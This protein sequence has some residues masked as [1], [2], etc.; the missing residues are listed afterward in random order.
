[1]DRAIVQPGALPQDTDILLTNKFA[2]LGQAYQNMALLGTSTVVAGLAATPTSPT[3][4]LHVTIGVGTIYQMTPTDAS[5]YGSLGVDNTSVMKQGVNS[6][7]QVLSIAPPA[8]SGFSQV[9]LVQAILNDADGGN[10]VLSYYNSA[11]PSQP[12]SGPGNAGTSNFT[13]RTSVCQIALKA[14]VAASTGTQ[15]APTPDAGYVGLYTITVA[16]GQTQI[17]STNIVQLA[18]APFFPSLPSVPSGVQNGTWVWGGS[19][20]GTA[21]NYAVTCT[22]I[23]IAYKAGMGI[24]FK[25]TNANSGASTINVNGL[26][27]VAIKRAGG[28]ALASGDIV[29]G[30]VVS[31]V[32]D[33]VNFQ[34]DNYLG[35]SGATTNITNN[36]IGLP[37]VNDTGSQNALIGTYSPAVTAYS[38]GLAITIKLANSITSSSTINCN[39]LGVKSI[40]L[41]DGTPT[42]A[43]MF[44]AGQILLLIY[45]GTAFQI[46]GTSSAVAK[47]LTSNYTMYVNKALGDDGNDG[48]ANVS[49]KALATIGRAMALAWAYGPS[50][51]TITIQVSAGT[52]NEPVSTPLQAG[53][54]VVI[55]GSGTSATTVN[56]GA[57]NTFVA[58]GPN[59]LTVQ[60]LNATNTGAQSN[61]VFLATQGASLTTNNTMSGNQAGNVF[62]G[63]SGGTVFPGNHTFNGNQYNCFSAVYGGTCTISTFTFTFAGPVSVT[64]AVAAAFGGGVLNV[65]NVNPPSFVNP[66]YVNGKK[67]D[68]QI[69]GVISLNG[70]GANF[71][72]G[73]VAGGTGNGGQFYP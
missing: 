6:S 38:A 64:N 34:M 4:D 45:D 31:L 46:Y 48:S 56:G 66:S 26:G 29:S 39:G 58:Q 23:P 5:A 2:L 35:I 24:R 41:G 8:T 44:V 40:T 67:F 17:T 36:S 18:T 57:N 72:P 33:G 7:P 13:I 70:L 20:T 25:A 32:Y 62:T 14:G 27:A 10:I 50:Q 43:N 16:N 53:P 42:L 55:N 52:Y 47:K 28:N 19:D 30:Q 3:A 60:N 22:P 9:Y 49:G 65:N 61:S 21:N 63:Q 54:N 12:F 11:N 68:A 71:F 69:N 37:Y 1:M 51:Y 59:T 15:V 73:S